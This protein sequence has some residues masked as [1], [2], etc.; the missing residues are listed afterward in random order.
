MKAKSIKNLMWGVTRAIGNCW[1]VF[2]KTEAAA[3][4]EARLRARKT[5]AAYIVYKWDEKAKQYLLAH[6]VQS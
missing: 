4:H 6:L 1:D 2:R 5:G 3:V